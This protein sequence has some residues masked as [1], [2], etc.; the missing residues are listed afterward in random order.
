MT[1]LRYAVGGS[2]R[3]I[4]HRV[5][6]VTGVAGRRLSLSSVLYNT[7]LGVKEGCRERGAFRSPTLCLCV[8]LYWTRV[9]YKVVQGREVRL[10]DIRPK[11]D[12]TS[13]GSA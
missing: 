11:S 2:R 6:G 4:G 5:G 9:F 7:A 10:E 8:R 13:W 12:V 3:T 1:R